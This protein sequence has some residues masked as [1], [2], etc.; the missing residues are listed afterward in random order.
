VGDTIEDASLCKQVATP[1]QN[2]SLLIKINSFWY[3]QERRDCR[4]AEFLTKRTFAQ[5][6]RKTKVF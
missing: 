3:L 5:R 2:S 6:S 1:R 4:E